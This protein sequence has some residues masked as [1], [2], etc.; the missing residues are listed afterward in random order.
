MECSHTKGMLASVLW[1]RTKPSQY[2]QSQS[3]TIKQEMFS[4]FLVYWIQLNNQCIQ[5]LPAQN[6]V[7]HILLREM[8]RSLEIV[9][10]CCVCK[11]S[12][13]DRLFPANQNW[14]NYVSKI[15]DYLIQILLFIAF[16][17]MINKF[18]IQ[19]CNFKK[20]TNS[21]TNNKKVTNYFN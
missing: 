5:N 8:Y 14:S 4:C 1:R 17:N 12:K 10:L 3:I 6:G 20:L 19:V 7:I 2:N 9:S 13:W 15:R 16:G 21:N 18:P 11:H